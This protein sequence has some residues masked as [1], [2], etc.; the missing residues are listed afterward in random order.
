[1]CRASLRSSAAPT[2]SSWPALGSS[3]GSSRTKGAVWAMKRR[4]VFPNTET[5]TARM[6]FTR[7][8][9]IW[10]SIRS[11]WASRQS[12]R[13]QIMFGSASGTRIPVKA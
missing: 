7:S 13:A 10:F 1:M 9:D 12:A 4:P 2:F 6:I 11:P 3:I 8:G 5:R